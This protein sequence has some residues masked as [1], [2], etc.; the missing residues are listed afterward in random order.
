MGITGIPRGWKQNLWYSGGDV[1]YFTGFSSECIAVFD[2]YGTS[3]STIEFT[4]HFFRMY[5]S[6]CLFTMVTHITS[7][8]LNVGNVCYFCGNGWGR[9]EILAGTGGDGMR[10]LRGW[11]G[12]KKK[13]DGDGWG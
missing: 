10:V 13:L 7:A 1:T 12:I 8:S 9:I 2:I 6:A 11:V 3:E 5:E 4:I